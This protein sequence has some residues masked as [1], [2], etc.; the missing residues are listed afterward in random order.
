MQ[1]LADVRNVP[2]LVV[3]NTEAQGSLHDQLHT[4]PGYLCSEYLGP[5]HE[6][7]EIV[8]DTIH[9][10]L[11]A[12]SYDDESID[13]VLSSDVFEHVP[14][15]YRAHAEV[16]RV[17]RP[18]GHHVFTVPFL[19]HGHLDDVR[20]RMGDDGEVEL[21][22]DAIY[23]DDP[24]RPEGV[25]VF[26]IFGLEMLVRLAELGFDTR[27]YCLRSPWH[28]IVGPNALVFDAVRTVV[29]A[30]SPEGLTDRA[31]RLVRGTPLED[32][33]RALARR[34][35]RVLYGTPPEATDASVAAR[36]PRPT[37]RRR[38]SCR[39]GT[40]TRP[41]RPWPT[42]TPTATACGARGP[43]RSPRSISASTSR[44]RCSTSSSRSTTS[45]PSRWSGRT[46]RATGSRTTASAT[47][48]RW[49]STA[50]S[51]TSHRS[52]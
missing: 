19:L 51:G 5:D 26:T 31:R 23:H 14:D 22:A 46:T 10:D 3:Y 50:C 39:P 2:D 11:M 49:R 24:V 9:Q 27:M 13:L 28:G 15:P 20:A 18:Q 36:R 29:S 37:A 30:G 45:S 41:S 42:S 33:S 7:G 48:T 32:P 25:L 34:I 47:A 16:H 35:R 12:L 52:G 43:S 6:P 38:C 4:M 44:R 1:S 17:L 21:L 40:S 8:G